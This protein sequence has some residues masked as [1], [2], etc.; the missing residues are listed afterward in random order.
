MLP[1]FPKHGVAGVQHI[2]GVIEF[3]G[4]RILDVVDQL[5]HVP[6]RHH[7]A[8]RHRHTAGFFED[9]AQFVKCF[10]NSVHGAALQL[11]RW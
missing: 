2:L 5:E 9:R 6:A 3:T 4:D 7:A 1:G 10:K 8:G 11:A